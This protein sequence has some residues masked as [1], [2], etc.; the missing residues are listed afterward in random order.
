M[1]SQSVGEFQSH[2]AQS[3][4]AHNADL[5]TGSDF[6]VAQR[7]IRGDAGAEQRGGRGRVQLLRDF[8]HEGLIDDDV[9]GI[10]TIS[11]A[12]RVLIGA[13]IRERRDPQ[14][15]LFEAAPAILAG[16]AGIDHAAD[17]GYIALSE[18][19]H[20]LSDLNH[21]AHDFVAGNY[22]VDGV[23]PLIA[24]LMQVGMTDPAVE[25]IDEYIVVGGVA[26]FDGEWGER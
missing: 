9:L 12:A 1:R 11:H 2:V 23:A 10:S 25:D 15:V 5:L 13:V 8:Q 7:R 26:P 17:G 6:P 16:A 18:F 4:Q 21:A 14:A 24:C 19:R 3:A 20:A 22:G